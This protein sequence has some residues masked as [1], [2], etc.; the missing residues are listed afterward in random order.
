MAKTKECNTVAGP[1][2]TLLCLLALEEK[3]WLEAAARLMT[4]L[5]FQILRR[6]NFSHEEGTEN[7][8]LNNYT[9]E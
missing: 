2:N 6:G 5:H 3:A 4:V 8:S 1:T 7:F 9:F